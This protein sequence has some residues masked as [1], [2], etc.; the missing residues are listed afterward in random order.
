MLDKGSLF[1]TDCRAGTAFDVLLNIVKWM[2][3]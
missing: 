2:I 1:L 3:I